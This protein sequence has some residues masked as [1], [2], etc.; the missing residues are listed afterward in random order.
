MLIG[1]SQQ[2]IA[3]RFRPIGNGHASEKENRHCRPHRPTMR[4]RTGHSPQRVREPATDGEN[5]N[6]FD[7]IGQR[8]RIL[9]RMRTV[10]IEEAAAVRSPI[11]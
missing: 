3:T 10:G 4:L 5:C 11:P 9:K 2:R 6:Q 7:Q 8:R 1:S